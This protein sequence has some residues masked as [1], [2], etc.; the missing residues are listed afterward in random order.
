MIQCPA[1]ADLL[2]LGQA[3]VGET[4]GLEAWVAVSG[5]VA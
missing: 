3:I 4:W 1:K 5:W 2:C